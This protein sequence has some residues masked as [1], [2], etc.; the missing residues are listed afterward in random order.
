MSKHSVPAE[1][2]QMHV[3]SA[4]KHELFS[5]PLPPPAT[6]DQ[7]EKILPGAADR[8]LKM[9]ETEQNNYYALEREKLERESA[10]S[11]TDSRIRLLGLLFG[12]IFALGIIAAA[13]MAIRKGMGVPACFF[14]SAAIVGVVRAFLFI[15]KPGKE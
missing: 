15:A 1:T 4:Q 11:R 5:G 6:F 12:F 7:Y 14:A 13:L 2:G 9:A 8:I 10:A 3:V